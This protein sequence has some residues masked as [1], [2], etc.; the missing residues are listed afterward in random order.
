MANYSPK[1]LPRVPQVRL[2]SSRVEFEFEFE[3]VK[4]VTIVTHDRIMIFPT[5]F[6]HATI[7]HPHPRVPKA[8]KL[9]L[10]ISFELHDGI[11]SNNFCYEALDR[12]HLTS[13]FSH[14]WDHWW[15]RYSPITI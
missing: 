10:L 15:R 4:A 7:L 9:D 12:P 13:L 3:P 11:C 1:M 2:R 14:L 8:P 6:R 5:I